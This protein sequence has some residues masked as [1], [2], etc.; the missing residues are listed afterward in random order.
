MLRK[1]IEKLNDYKN[2]CNLVISNDYY[3]IGEKLSEKGN[4]KTFTDII[5]QDYKK[6]FCLLEKSFHAILE[7]IYSE[8]ESK[9]IYELLN[10]T[11]NSVKI[12]NTETYLVDKLFM[13]EKLNVSK[14]DFKDEITL[15]CVSFEQN[16]TS[17]EAFLRFYKNNIEK[18]EKENMKVF[19]F[20]ENSKSVFDNFLILKANGVNFFYETGNN[21]FLKI[22]FKPSQLECTYT[23]EKEFSLKFINTFLENSLQ[24]INV[25]LEIFLDLS[26]DK[27][28]SIRFSFNFK[29]VC[30]TLN[31]E[32]KIKNRVKTK[33]NDYIYFSLIKKDFLFSSFDIDIKE[34]QYYKNL[35][36]DINEFINSFYNKFQEG[37]FKFNMDEDILT[38]LTL[39]YK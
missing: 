31:L 8:I 33:K 13:N 9:K 5:I 14:F 21:L 12:K 23:P 4:N 26:L 22:S 35:M 34:S 17:S 15:R 2:H 20:N 11:Y 7:K 36:L 25:D 19:S 3:L 32:A 18:L 39:K 29:E 6:V 30:D 24:Y 16:C 37:I 28:I 27:L 10:T 38:F 1:V